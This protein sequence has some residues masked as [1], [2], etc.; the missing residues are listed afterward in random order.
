MSGDNQYRELLVSIPLTADAVLEIDGAGHSFRDDFLSR[1]PL[2]AYHR[3]DMDEGQWRNGA[4]AMKA[5][6]SIAGNGVFDAILLSNSLEKMLAPREVLAGLRERA[7]PG[8]TCVARILN[9]GHWSVIL[10]QLR[11]RWNDAGQEMTGAGDIRFFTLDSAMAMFHGAGWAISDIQPL[12]DMPE[13]QGLIKSLQAIAQAQ[14]VAAGQSRENLLAR[15]WIIRAVNGHRPQPVN[16][17]A[18]GL[19]KVA[20]VT[21]ARVDN[22]MEALGSLPGMRVVWGA[23]NVTIPGGWKPGVFILHRQF[24]HEKKFQ[25]NM[26]KLVQQGW[27]LV[28]DMDDDPRHWQ[29]FVDSD[30]YAFRGVHA[31]TV[32]TAPLADLMGEWN[33]HV[34]IFPN[35]ISR[36]PGIPPGTPKQ[37]GNRVRVF[38]GAL[39]RGADWEPLRSAIISAALA[40]AGRV[41]F[42]IVHDRAV[43]DSLPEG[44]AREYHPTLPPEKYMEVLATCDIGLLPL[45]DNRFNRL[46]SDLKFIECCAAGVVPL[47]SP[48]VYGENPAHRHIGV[49]AE[50]DREWQEALLFLVNNPD[51][52]R[53]RRELGLAYVKRE[54]MHANQVASRATY[55][56]QLFNQ[57]E[58]LE[59]ARRQRLGLAD[60]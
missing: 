52:I 55:Y 41:E 5:I 17:V 53:S 48:V 30:F 42:V 36:L 23:G 28:S 54:R 58:M 8:G 19:K 18:M 26:E 25:E 24:M 37:E 32:S 2:A 51:E 10:D 7:S 60:E 34:Q 6:D 15:E 31:V 22:P 40:L 12:Y 39:N 21:E 13:D 11:G 57:R 1:K 59:K 3:L 43:Y 4:G 14:G 49:F 44:I 9:V 45:E 27:L 38:F 47:C 16:V 20:G 56:R 33:P 35:G 46:K 29:E 50:N